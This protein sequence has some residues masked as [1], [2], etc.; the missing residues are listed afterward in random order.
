MKKLYTLALMTFSA[1]VGLN[2]QE[3]VMPNLNDFTLDVNPEY[4]Q[5]VNANAI[6]TTTCSDTSYY[7]MYK[8]GIAGE[9]PIVRDGSNTSLE[10]AG[11]IYYNSSDLILKGFKVYVSNPGMSPVEASAHVYAVDESHSVTS[12]KGFKNITV[13]P[14]NFQSV[15]VEF[16]SPINVNGDFMVA[17]EVLPNGAADTLKVAYGM[18]GRTE[19]LAYTGYH[20]GTQLGAWLSFYNDLMADADY[21][22]FPIYETEV[23]ADISVPTQVFKNDTFDFTVNSEIVELTDSMINFSYFFGAPQLYTDFYNLAGDEVEESSIGTLS[24]TYSYDTTGSRNVTHS[25]VWFSWSTLFLD[26]SSPDF[27]PVFCFDDIT[28]TIEVLSPVGIDEKDFDFNWI[29]ND[30]ALS[31]SNPFTG[32][33]SVFTAD[34][35]LISQTDLNNANFHEVNLNAS[36]L[37]I[38]TLTSG[39]TLKSLKVIH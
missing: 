1:V 31:F 18:S 21:M 37:Y 30:E 16:D 10:N 27:T 35:R 8:G 6:M 24:G 2:A 5:A 23:I 15:N 32:T 7:P 39:Q 34:G 28:K 9:F 25:A 36:G 38:I 13:S 11:Q 3:K 22:I 26:P 12:R 4:Q 20:D 33:V 29:G 19:D 17:L 14:G